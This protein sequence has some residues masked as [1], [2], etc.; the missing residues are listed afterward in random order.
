[1]LA[2]FR[3]RDDDRCAARL[4]HDERVTVARSSDAGGEQQA[5]TS[6]PLP[7]AVPPTPVPTAA[8]LPDVSEL[9]I[10]ADPARS[11]GP[12]PDARAGSRAATEPITHLIPIV[13][14]IV[15]AR[16]RGDPLADD[17]VQETL[18]R[19][20]TAIDRIDASMLEPYAI[21]TARNVL[22]NHWRGQDRERRNQHRALEIAIDGPSDSALLAGEDRSAMATALS[23]LSERDRALVLAHE[24]S[25]VDTATLAARDGSTPGAVAAQLSRARAKLRIEYLLAAE[26]VELPTPQCR[27]VLLAL[28]AADRR[29]QRELDAARHLLQCNVCAQLSTPLLARGKTSDDQIRVGISVDAD[30]VTARQ[31]ARE[32]ASRLSFSATALTTIATAVSEIARNIVR[33]AGQG[34]I[35]VELLRRPRAGVQIVARDAGPGIVD[36][37]AALTEGYSTYHGLGLGL[38]GARRLMDEFQLV[39]E[40]GRGTTVTMTKWDSR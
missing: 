19:V 1:M 4:G 7:A 28:S 9:T 32:L 5:P 15:H 10:A 18:T 17:L 33:F 13:R 34:E 26:H 8:P 36:T 30:I 3:C 25:G 6:V 35:V 22:A 29:R 40:P 12:D 21:S 39:S 37:Q 11:P 27:P 2:L 20:M 14:R 31:A 16:L 38:P 24:V 23:K